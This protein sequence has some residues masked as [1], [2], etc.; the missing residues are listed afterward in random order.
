MFRGL[1]IIL[2]TTAF[3]AVA[4]IP[5]LQAFPEPNPQLVKI[6]GGYPVVYDDFQRADGDIH[7]S[8]TPYG[9]TYWTNVQG[10]QF[11][12]DGH[13]TSEVIGNDAKIAY[14]TMKQ[15]PTA[16]AA[17]FEFTP[18]HLDHRA[19]VNPN[20]LPNAVIGASAKGFGRGSVQLAVSPD[21][22]K[23]FVVENP[24]VDPYPVLARGRF[25]GRLEYG[26]TY[27]MSLTFDPK[28]SSVTVTVPR[29]APRTVTNPMF[30]RY[31]GDTIGMQ[32]RR[33]SAAYGHIRFKALAAR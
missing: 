30:A 16:I 6:L 23:L 21:Q 24:I 12:E 22:W 26:K 14:I 8:I 32:I 25:G 10:G 4:A 7:Q 5:A 28:T 11:I 29:Y 13:Y 33:P 18:H 9:Q 20:Y 3:A 17:A 2:A 15:A 19:D 31:W 27:R 1:K